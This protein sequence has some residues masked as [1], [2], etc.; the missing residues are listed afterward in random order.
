MKAV[1]MP[2]FSE[3]EIIVDPSRE[4]VRE[5]DFSLIMPWFYAPWPG[6]QEKGIIE[7]TFP[8]DSLRALLTELSKRYREANVDFELINP[9]ANDLDIDYDVL[10]NGQN[11]V[12]LA[13]GLDVKL[14]ADD[15]VKI[16]VLWRWDG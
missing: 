5:E 1:I 9:G 2:G 12:A 16:K 6:S 4:V 11:Y 14:K 13:G 3:L 15:T 7:M 8:G 10:V